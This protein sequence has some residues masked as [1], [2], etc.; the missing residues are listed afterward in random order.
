MKSAP[1]KTL[2]VRIRAELHK[3]LK[4]MK[5]EDG[6]NTADFVESLIEKALTQKKCPTCGGVIKKRD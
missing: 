1:R 4:E 5:H 2:G 6:L 3:K